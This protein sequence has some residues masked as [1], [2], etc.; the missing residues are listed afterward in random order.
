MTALQNSTRWL[1]KNPIDAQEFIR[2]LERR[3]RTATDPLERAS[4]AD[5]LLPELVTS[6]ETDRCLA[7]LARVP[8][9]IPDRALAV[10]ILALRGVV[11]AMRGLDVDDVTRAV[12]Q[13]AGLPESDVVVVLGRA[14]VAASLR[15]DALA[16]QRYALSALEIAER[17]GMHHTAARIC[18]T[19]YATHFHL[20]QDLGRRCSGSNA[21]RCSH[22]T[23]AT[24]RF[25]G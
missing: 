2:E 19:L 25:G 17:I 1:R 20:T 8:L 21:R 10:R 6:Y 11:A 15:K 5:R 4:I 18:A 16:A 22:T 9:H 13:T 24:S 3:F 7:I 14:M 12:A 23:P